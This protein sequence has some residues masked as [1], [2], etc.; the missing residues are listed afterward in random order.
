MG[1]C[2]SKGKFIAPALFTADACT[3]YHALQAMPAL[4]QCLLLAFSCLP[5]HKCRGPLLSTC[6]T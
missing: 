5:M 6:H 4:Q 3:A 2:R 1:K